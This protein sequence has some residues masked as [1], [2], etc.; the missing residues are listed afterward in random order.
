MRETDVAGY[1]SD[2]QVLKTAYRKVGHFLC[3][4]KS[5]EQGRQKRKARNG[6][7]LGKVQDL[8]VNEFCCCEGKPRENS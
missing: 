3:L 6:A 1:F 7:W 2:N 5:D 8:W 4:E